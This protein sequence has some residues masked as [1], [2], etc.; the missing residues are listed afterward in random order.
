MTPEIQMQ[1]VPSPS[2]VFPA[3]GGMTNELQPTMS[4]RGGRGGVK[5]ERIPSREMTTHEQ[6]AGNQ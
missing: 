3:L 2:Q 5:E 4:K 1:R 6:D